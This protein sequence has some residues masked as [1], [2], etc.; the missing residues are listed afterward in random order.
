MNAILAVLASASAA[1][2]LARVPTYG[3][4]SRE[5][6]VTLQNVRADAPTFQ[7]LL[8]EQVAHGQCVT[9][10]PGAEVEG[11]HPDSASST[12]LVNA[13]SDPPGYVVPMGDFKPK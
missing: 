2:Y 8:T 4:S 7:R 5:Q 6:V 12:L 13:K 11:S 10:P 9:I 3:C 1:M